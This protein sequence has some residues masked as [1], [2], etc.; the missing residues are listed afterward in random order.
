MLDSLINCPTDSSLTFSLSLF[1]LSLFL[2]FS[3]SLFLLSPFL[4]LFLFLF[5][6]FSWALARRS[7]WGWTKQKEK[8]QTERLL[9]RSSEL[10]EIFFG[11]CR[12]KWLRPAQDRELGSC[13]GLAGHRSAGYR[14]AGQD[15]V[16][17]ANGVD[18][19]VP[20]IEAADAQGWH[21]LYSC[22]QKHRYKEET[23][24]EGSEGIRVLCLVKWNSW[25][26][27]LF[28]CAKGEGRKQ[29]TCAG[30]RRGGLNINGT[31]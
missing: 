26:L 17:P 25:N 27:S 2:F 29:E 11:V 10:A 1:S 4:F 8:T 16:L 24:A 14:A 23:E 31:G 22:K 7:Y 12:E 13:A 18:Q 9:E 5:F 21:T 3:F 6:S 30:A 20:G 15:Q 19:G 28:L